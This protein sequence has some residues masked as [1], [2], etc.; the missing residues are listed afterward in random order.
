[1][2]L[3]ANDIERDAESH[4]V[5]TEGEDSVGVGVA[6]GEQRF[7]EEFCHAWGVAMD[8]KRWRSMLVDVSLFRSLCCGVRLGRYIA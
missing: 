4:E 3:N 5:E 1:M 6:R 8:R 7:V 2:E